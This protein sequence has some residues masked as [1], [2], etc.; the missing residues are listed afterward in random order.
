MKTPISSGNVA[1]AQQFTGLY[2]DVMNNFPTIAIAL[3]VLVSAPVAAQ[4]QK[5]KAIAFG[6]LLVFLPTSLLYLLLKGLHMIRITDKSFR[7]TPSFNTDLRK[8]FRKME[9]E[10]RAAEA[11]GKPSEL[12]TVHRLDP[13]KKPAA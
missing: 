10:R 12:A 1:G 6:F 11:S 13:A 8:K 5:L 7:Y 3:A 9:Q 4:A 2:C